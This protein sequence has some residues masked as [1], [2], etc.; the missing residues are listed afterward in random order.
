MGFLLLGRREPEELW[1]KIVA[2]NH[3]T[4]KGS[5]EGNVLARVVS[6]LEHGERKV[7]AENLLAGIEE[8][9]ERSLLMSVMEDV[10][11]DG[12]KHSAAQVADSLQRI[13]ADGEKE[14]IRRDIRNS[15][16]EAEAKRYGREFQ[17]LM[18]SEKVPVTSGKDGI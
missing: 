9:A 12:G 14:L 6:M 13:C 4:I 5:V 8:D 7:D 3:D 10:E 1:N 16:S 15:R 18:A 17:E 2:V 11:S